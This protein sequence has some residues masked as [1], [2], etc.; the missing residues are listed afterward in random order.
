VEKPDKVIDT[1]IAV[2]FSI[3][4]GAWIAMLFDSAHY[5]YRSVENVGPE[6]V[7]VVHSGFYIHF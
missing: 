5:L 4:H 7:I 6:L 1:W 2:S 3:K